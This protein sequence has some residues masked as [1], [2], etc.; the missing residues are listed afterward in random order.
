MLGL[1]DSSSQDDSDIDDSSYPL[2]E[3]QDGQKQ[4]TG[5]RSLMRSPT[6]S[7]ANQE[8]LLE[9][10][11]LDHQNDKVYQ[12]TISNNQRTASLLCKSGIKINQK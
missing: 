8:T 10:N 5:P 4:N 11:V 6:S 2:L 3:K 1:P 7:T 12:L 9:M